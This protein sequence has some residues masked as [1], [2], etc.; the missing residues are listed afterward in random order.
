MNVK[1]Q[2]IL[3]TGANRG[4]GKAY[5]EEF[6]KAG[7]KKIYLGVRDPEKARSLAAKDPDKLEIIRLDVANSADIKTAIQTAKDVNIIISNAGVLMG[8]NLRDK[9]IED[10][11]RWEMEVNYFGPLALI[12]AFAPILKA[13]GGGAIVAV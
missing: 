6:L 7:A 10:H 1:D 13:N 3:V 11:A 5:V 9:N 12:Q 2:V 4:I 8:G